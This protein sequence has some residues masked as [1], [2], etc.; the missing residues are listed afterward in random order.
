MKSYS[1]LVT[2]P[3]FKERFMYLSLS[4][5][6]G[7]RTFGGSRILNQIFYTSSEWK[8]VRNEILIRDNGCDLGIED[9]PIFGKILIHHIVPITIKDVEDR[10]SILLDPDNL[11]CVSS[12][13]HQAI[14]YGEYN[15][16]LDEII[17]RVPNDTCP[18]RKD[19]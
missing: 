7:E 13:T 8:R 1:E 19:A 16:L 12:L 3:T 11:I 14:H 6:I 9:R 5:N 15:S 17:E 2:L 4:G 18:W 10:N